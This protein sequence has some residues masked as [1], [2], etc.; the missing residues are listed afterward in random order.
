MVL[1]ILQ[2]QVLVH[3]AESLKDKRRVV[4]SLKDRLHREHLCA[5]AEVGDPDLLNVATIALAVIAR[6]G[7]RAGDVLDSITAK[8]RELRDGE[9]GEIDRQ[10]LQG[11]GGWL[12]NELPEPETVRLEPGRT[13]LPELARV[14]PLP[15]GPRAV[16]DPKAGDGSDESIDSLILE[17]ALDADLLAQIE[18]ADRE[19]RSNRKG[20]DAA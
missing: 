6:E 11:S 3:G 9:V 5:I 8:L 10:I 13:E 19:M 14:E 1:G 7:K 15:A 18:E 2:F 4:Q 17:R 12:P 16:S 20:G